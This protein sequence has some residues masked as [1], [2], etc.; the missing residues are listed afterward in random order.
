MIIIFSQFLVI[1]IKGWTKYQNK[2]IKVFDERV[3]Y[4]IAENICELS[5]ATIVSLHSVEEI[6]FVLKL[7]LEI[8]PTF[9]IEEG[10]IWIGAKTTS[11]GVYHIELYNR[12]ILNNSFWDKPYDSGKY[13][14][15][16]YDQSAGAFVFKEDN[17]AVYK[18][19]FACEKDPIE[20]LVI[21]SFFLKIRENEI[22]Y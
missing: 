15:I 14:G 19:L 5:G 10:S 16:F 3:V 9:Y 17:G 7:V 8:R 2:C 22:I 11:S 18:A 20:E 4:P 1:C 13:V 21:K 12:K 6:E